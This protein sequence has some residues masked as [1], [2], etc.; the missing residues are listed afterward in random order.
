MT[1]LKWKRFI[2]GKYSKIEIDEKSVMKELEQAKKDNSTI[3][4][5]NLSEIELN[6]R[7]NQM[8]MIR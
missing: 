7:N 6:L 5:Y 1:E 8:K 4:E 2:F 3:K